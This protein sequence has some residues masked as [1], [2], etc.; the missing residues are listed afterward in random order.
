MQDFLQQENGI[1]DLPGPAPP[2]G[3]QQD[4]FFPA[5]DDSQFSHYKHSNDGLKQAQHYL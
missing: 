4:S 5:S 2:P 3:W 1:L